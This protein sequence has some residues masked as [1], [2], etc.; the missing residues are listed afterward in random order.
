[1]PNLFF[2]ITSM[3]MTHNIPKIHPRIDTPIIPN[4]PSLPYSR[5]FIGLCFFA[6]ISIG[7]FFGTMWG[8]VRALLTQSSTPVSQ[9]SFST[10]FLPSLINPLTW[11]TLIQTAY[12]RFLHASWHSG[13]LESYQII[14]TAR[15]QIENEILLYPSLFPQS[16]KKNRQT[17][18]TMRW[19]IHVAMCHSSLNLALTTLPDITKSLDK[20]FSLQR[21]SFVMIARASGIVRRRVGEECVTRSLEI[22]GEQWQTNRDQKER[23]EKAYN[24]LR[25]LWASISAD[26]LQCLAL[27]TVFLDNPDGVMTDLANQELTWTMIEWLLSQDLGAALELF[28][29]TNPDQSS[30]DAPQPNQNNSDSQTDQNKQ[31]TN[32]PNTDDADP[33]QSWSG[34]EPR[35]DWAQG[36]G[37]WQWQTQSSQWSQGNWDDDTQSWNSWWWQQPSD[38]LLRGIF[39]DRWKESNQT[40]QSQTPWGNTISQWQQQLDD[41]TQTPPPLEDDSERAGWLSK[42]Q[43]EFPAE[44]EGYVERI[45]RSQSERQ[46]WVDS[47]LRNQQYG[48]YTEILNTFET[49]LGDTEAFRERSRLRQNDD[50]SIFEEWNIQNIQ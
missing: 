37:Q 17:A 20:I 49:F 23:F 22:I 6:V 41:I 48:P 11:A 4:L 28:C 5:W 34:Q 12:D 10:P 15:D 2:I 33:D 39:S 47:R 8:D 21:K 16:Q 32:Q 35:E 42:E 29:M 13:L 3:I 18:T 25:S 36:D 27:P 26:P 38:H 46:Q 30:Q 40:N 43:Q 45:R 14:T 50:R 19:V 1:M 31:A 24:S 9:R 44:W 7:I